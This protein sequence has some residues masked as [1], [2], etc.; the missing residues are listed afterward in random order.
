M[1]V[2]AT[3]ESLESMADQLTSLK[4]TGLVD[5]FAE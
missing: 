2:R 1:K 5:G 3:C 4:N